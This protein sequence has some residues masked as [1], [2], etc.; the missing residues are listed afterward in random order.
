[1]ILSKLKSS[2]LGKL[3]DQLSV[4]QRKDFLK[5]QFLIVVSALLELI[6][7]SSLVPLLSLLSGSQDSTQTSLIEDFVFEF[8]SDDIIVIAGA[9]IFLLCTSAIISIY[10]LWRLSIFSQL[11]AANIASRLFKLYIF[12]E[13]EKSVND[14]SS[15]MISNVIQEV[16]RLRDAVIV[17]FMFL[18][19]K[20]SVAVML[21]L[22]LLVYDFY[23]AL[24]V[25][26]FLIILYFLMYGTIRP[27]LSRIG[28]RITEKNQKVVSRIND[29][30]LALRE[31]HIRNGRERAVN[32]LSMEL[33][34]LG[35][36][37]VKLT[38]LGQ[39]PKYFIEFL[40]LGSIGAFSIYFTLTNSVGNG[41][42]FSEMAIY[43]VAG[44]KILPAIQHIFSHVVQIKSNIQ[45]YDAIHN[46]LGMERELSVRLRHLNEN[47]RASVLPFEKNIQLKN[48]SYWFDDEKQKVIKNINLQIKRGETVAIIGASGSGKSTLLDLIIGIRQSKIGALYID[49]TK[50]NDTNLRSW[51]ANVSFMPQ[52]SFLLDDTVR[53]N[54]AFGTN[55]YSIE[56]DKIN[57]IIKQVGLSPV[58]TKSI[59][60][61]H[62]RIGERGGLFSGGE[63][64]R[65][66]IAR[67]LYQDKPVIFIDEATSALDA[68]SELEIH[69]CLDLLENK[70]I[71][72]ITHKLSTIR[73]CD[74]IIV[75]DDGEIIGIGSHDELIKSN[76]TFQKLID[77]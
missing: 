30:F 8:F 29:A 10:T 1:M 65:I 57:S 66:G 44:F 76:P 14:N 59:N 54:I 13:L 24:S 9:T 75:V 47:F 2:R 17:P 35:M 64:Q 40:A 71:V 77:S 45:S 69:A 50:I 49:G 56:D 21:I 11:I 27:I 53:K 34:D 63:R 25:G 28:W 18:L 36:M 74:K 15:R 68:K 46:D 61:I 16:S 5:L 67:L 3:Y 19:A 73:K 43:A 42:I 26:G 12:R 52:Q 31:L 58:I 37:R 23:V 55:D 38:V 6:S 60:G 22:A 39:V 48:V 51:F 32:E 62:S 33:N 4:G 70:T 7:L 41:D 72:F 20:L